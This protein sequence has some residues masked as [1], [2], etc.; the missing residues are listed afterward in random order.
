VHKDLKSL[1]V[2]LTKEKHVKVGDFGSTEVLIHGRT[3]AMGEMTE[4]F[5]AP[6]FFA[7][8]ASLTAKFDVYVSIAI[9][10]GCPV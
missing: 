8:A 10:S 2:F 9:T 4:L 1:N 5:I 3:P 6:E 7:G